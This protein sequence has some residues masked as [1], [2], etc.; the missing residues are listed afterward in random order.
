MARKDKLLDILSLAQLPL[1]AKIARLARRWIG[2]PFDRDQAKAVVKCYLE[3]EGRVL[4]L[5]KRLVESK[6]HQEKL[7]N[8][9]KALA[10]A[11]IERLRSPMEKYRGPVNS[12]RKKIRT[13]Q[14]ARKTFGQAVKENFNSDTLT[15]MSLISGEERSYTVEWIDAGFKPVHCALILVVTRSLVNRCQ[16]NVLR[17]RFL[18]YRAGG[19]VLVLRTKAG[20]CMDAWARALPPALVEAAQTLKD[21]GY[22]LKPDLESQEMVI[23]DPDGCEA[24]RVAWE[25][26]T[27][28]G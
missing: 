25:G 26:S 13:M 20:T 3:G 27:V 8:E 10:D 19:R 9:R 12:W 15:L 11:E 4:T 28:D 18:L 2:R 14:I 21:G 16:T 22:T 7:R 17:A 6:L 1:E 24:K 5:A 23:T